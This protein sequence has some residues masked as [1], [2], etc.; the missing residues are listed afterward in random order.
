MNKP[1]RLNSAEIT[2]SITACANLIAKNLSDNE[3][4]LLSAVFM[5]L[6]DTLTTISVVRTINAQNAEKCKN[7]DK[8]KG[9]KNS[10]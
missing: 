7:S 5:Q 2:A 1:K 4:A 10:N 8:G 9:E 3:L 6:A